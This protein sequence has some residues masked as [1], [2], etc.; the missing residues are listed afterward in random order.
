M[1]QEVCPVTSNNVVGSNIFV[2]SICSPEISSTV[3]PGQFVNIKVNERTVPLLRRPFSVY[4]V[5]GDNLEIIFNVI[6]IGTKILSSKS[7]GDVINVMGPLGRWYGIDGG[8]ETALLIAGG[9]GVAPLPMITAALKRK[10]GKITTFLGA[11]TSDQLVCSHLENINLA[12]DDGS[13]GYHGTIVD[14]LRSWLGRNNHAR[15]KI[16]GCGPNTMLKRLSYLAQEYN[17]PCEVSLESAMACG[18][19]ICQGCPVEKVGNEQKYSLIC[20]EGPVF[21]TRTIVI[22]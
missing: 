7:P 21:N 2:L 19:G 8:Y 15:F 1:I 17:I 22:E 13:V 12:T 14:C 16:F 4:R 18:I 11:R 9:L 3:Q 6:G 5:N 10:G 20:K